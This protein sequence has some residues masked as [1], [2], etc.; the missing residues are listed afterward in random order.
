MLPY[1]VLSIWRVPRDFSS[2]TVFYTLHTYFRNI[3][4]SCVVFKLP[5]NPLQ[6]VV[7]LIFP[8]PTYSS[9][10]EQRKLIAI[11]YSWLKAPAKRKIN[12]KFNYITKNLL[13]V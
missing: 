13:G 3:F 6:I 2:A 12:L 1:Q 10:R 7:A 8:F 4:V 11:I 5:R 9:I